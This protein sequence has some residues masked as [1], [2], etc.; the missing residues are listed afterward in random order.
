MAEPTNQ[1]HDA[2]D[3]PRREYDNGL[4]VRFVEAVSSL[5]PALDNIKQSI[6]DSSGRIP[7]VSSQLSSVTEATES[8]TVQ[9]LNV[10][11]GLTQ[12]VAQAEEG[13]NRLKSRIEGANMLSGEVGDEFQKIESAFTQTKES[14]MSI[15]MALQVQDITSQQIAGV[16]HMIESVRIELMKILEHFGSG[17]LDAAHL[18]EP[19]TGHFDTNA[20]YAGS[21]ERQEQADIIIKQWNSNSHE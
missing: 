12:S 16:K 17:K 3:A 9:I 18:V 10:L 21:G 15:A 1:Q 11:D 19:S 6:E 13:V 14:A 4:F 8:A 2:D 7:K 20:Q 5:V